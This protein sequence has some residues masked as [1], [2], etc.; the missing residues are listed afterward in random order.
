MLDEKA[1]DDLATRLAALSPEDAAQVHRTV[2]GLQAE[3][4]RAEEARI[5]TLR[6]MT[7]EE[8]IYF[9]VE[10]AM[11][12]P[13]EFSMSEPLALSLLRDAGFVRH[14]A[15]EAT[16]RAGYERGSYDAAG[17]SHDLPDEDDD[18]YVRYRGFDLDRLVK[19]GA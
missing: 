19:K 10:H 17:G 1:I 16:Y 11:G 12:G 3:R 13:H 14:A 2:S 5:A 6:A 9:A 8:A 4:A 7:D 18:E 15:V